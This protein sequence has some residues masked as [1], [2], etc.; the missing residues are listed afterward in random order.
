MNISEA[1][2]EA[3]LGT[4]LSLETV[5]YPR[6]SNIQSIEEVN[7]ILIIFVG[8]TSLWNHMWWLPTLWFH[9]F[10]VILKS[11]IW[12]LIH[13]NHQTHLIHNGGQFSLCKKYFILIATLDRWEK[14]LFFCLFVFT[15][16][17]K[18]EIRKVR[19][20]QNNGK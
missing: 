6:Q 14:C 11:K 19:E 4:F 2:Y 5:S 10:F 16:D 20:L 3:N 8:L 9:T 18:M 15:E 1:T 17:G 12:K 13:T 7:Y